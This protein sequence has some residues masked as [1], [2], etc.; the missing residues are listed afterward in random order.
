[1][2]KEIDAK[3][4]YLD[5]NIDHKFTVELDRTDIK[6]LI[7]GYVNRIK[8]GDLPRLI[9]EYQST[10][11]IDR[12]S[13][14]SYRERNLYKMREVNFHIR[15][16]NWNFQ[17]SNGSYNRTTGRI[18]TKKFRNWWRYKE[19]HLTEMKSYYETII[20]KIVHFSGLIGYDCS[21]IVAEINLSDKLKRSHSN[22]WEERR[23]KLG[24]TW[25]C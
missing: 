9:K 15:M 12:P 11:M 21:E 3:L 7:D 14:D 13:E 1:M 6:R 25:E 18:E 5:P 23:Q 8:L 10:L 2:T 4:V 20:Q 24:D 22:Y 17:V 19:Y 16:K